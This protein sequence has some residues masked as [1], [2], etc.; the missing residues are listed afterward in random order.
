MQISQ[1]DQV[2]RN[3]P[4]VP[5]WMPVLFI[6]HH[7]IISDKYT[8]FGNCSKSFKQ[9]LSQISVSVF[10]VSVMAVFIGGQAFC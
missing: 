1:G 6:Y 5:S 7:R 9:R 3:V 4:I 2:D 8:S 10:L